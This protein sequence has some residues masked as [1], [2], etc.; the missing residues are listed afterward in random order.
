MS[1][2]VKFK[3]ADKNGKKENFTIHIKDS[4]LILQSSLAKLAKQFKLEDKGIFPYSFP[5]KNN[6]DY[7]GKV[8]KYSFFDKTKLTLS[9][10]LEYKSSFSNSLWNLRNEVLKYCELDCILLYDIL[11]NFNDLIFD[12]SDINIDNTY[13]LPSLAFKIYRSKFMPSEEKIDISSG[14][15]IKNKKGKAKIV[16][17]INII[18]TDLY[19]ELKESYYGGHVDMYIPAGPIAKVNGFAKPDDK[20]IVPHNNKYIYHYDVNSLYPTVMKDYKYPNKLFAKFIGDI[21]YMDI[22]KNLYNSMLGIYNVVVTA[23]FNIKHPILPFKN[24]NFT[25]FP[26]GTWTG[27]Y[28]SE[29]LKNAE[30]YGYKFE[31]LSGYLFTSEDLFSDYVETFY[32]VKENLEKDSPMYLIAK[33]L[34]NSLY[35]RFGINPNLEKHI[36]AS[37]KDID[38]KLKTDTAYLDDLIDLDDFVICTFD[39]SNTRNVNSNVAIASFVTAYARILMSKFMNL[40][41]IKLFYTDTDS[42]FTDKPLDKTLVDSKK[43]GYLKLEDKY[44][45]FCSIGPK[46]WIGVFDNNHISCKLKGSKVKINY[47]DFLSLLSE[48]NTKTLNHVKWFKDFTNSCIIMKDTPHILKSTD[49]KRFSV[50]YNGVIIGTKSFHIIAKYIRSSFIKK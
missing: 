35:G 8:P 9:Q 22:Y 3:I 28:C 29:E 31:I 24:D 19:D 18:G 45:F 21:R 34:L 47:L 12:L 13:S 16:G 7:I 43:L 4:Y 46:N 48:G 44:K 15:I 41:H 36:I 32:K 27:M 14:E 20:A 2:S 39:N 40:N 10:Y 17:S 50:K 38:N 25:I 6:L 33:M 11:K 49:N 23:P 37:K 42:V 30:K 1:I 5:N 26:T